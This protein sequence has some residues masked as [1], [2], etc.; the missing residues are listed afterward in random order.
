MRRGHRMH[1]VNLAAGGRAAVKLGSIPGGDT[2]LNK[3]IGTTE[4]VV[5]FTEDDVGRRVSPARRCRCRH[6]TCLLITALA[7]RDAEG[8][9][10]KRIQQQQQGERSLHVVFL[11]LWLISLA[12][13]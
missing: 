8:T 7:Y 13:W 1:I 4:H 11:Y 12:S 2:A 9:G 10:A 3:P 5:A 6:P